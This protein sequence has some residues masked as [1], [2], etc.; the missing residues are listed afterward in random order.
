MCLLPA[1]AQRAAGTH[2]LL[3]YQN[4]SRPP[5]PQ[6]AVDKVARDKF[7]IYTWTNFHMRDFLMN[8]ILWL[9]AVRWPFF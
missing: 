2:D 5:L 4:F 6:E 8:W 9:K 1:E 7:I 3:Y